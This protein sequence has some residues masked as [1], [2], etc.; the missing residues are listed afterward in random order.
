MKYLRLEWKQIAKSSDKNTPKRSFN[1]IMKDTGIHT[2]LKGQFLL[3]CQIFQDHFAWSG[4]F[5]L[6]MWSARYLSSQNLG[7]G[8]ILVSQEQKFAIFRR[9]KT[10]S[11][12]KKIPSS[13]NIKRREKG[14]SLHQMN[15]QECFENVMDQ[16]FIILCFQKE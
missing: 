9:K 16:Y 14:S 3:N 1:K 11:K 4:N 13:K 7:R 2:I 8:S 15:F 12:H 10:N 6:E 5:A